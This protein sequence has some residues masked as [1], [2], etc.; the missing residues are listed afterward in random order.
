MP[1]DGS[2]GNL[3]IHNAIIQNNPPTILVKV[4][5]GALRGTFK[6]G[7]K[8]TLLKPNSSYYQNVDDKYIKVVVEALE[9]K[10]LLE[11]EITVKR[12]DTHP[13][14]LVV[15]INDLTTKIGN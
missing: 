12:G 7:E 8:T 5:E 3:R 14:K 13:V 4:Y 10:D 15:A 11:G 1:S 6:T 2:K 9:R